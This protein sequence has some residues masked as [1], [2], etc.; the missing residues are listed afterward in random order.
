MCG[1]KQSSNDRP[2]QISRENNIIQIDLPDGSAH[3]II[4]V[5]LGDVWGTQRRFDEFLKIKLIKRTVKF[6]LK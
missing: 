3:Q 2:I 1:C 5:Y 4:H 6:V